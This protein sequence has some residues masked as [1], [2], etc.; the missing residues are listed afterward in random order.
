MEKLDKLVGLKTV[1]ETLH[2]ILNTIQANQQSGNDKNFG[3]SYHMIFAGDPGTG[4]TTVAKIVAQ[5]L[6]E[7]GAIPENKWIG[8]AHV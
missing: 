7:V 4:K 5:A 3:F 1:K 2:S 8:R 6:F